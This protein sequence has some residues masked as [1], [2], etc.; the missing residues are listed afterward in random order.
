MTKLASKT[1]QPLDYAHFCVHLKTVNTILDPIHN[2]KAAIVVLLQIY[3][4]ATIQKPNI[5]NQH[6]VNKAVNTGR[7]V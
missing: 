3:S 1:V 4:E 2:F 5:S 6:I 7:R